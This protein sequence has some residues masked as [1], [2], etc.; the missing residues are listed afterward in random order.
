MGRLSTVEGFIFFDPLWRLENSKACLNSQLLL[1]GVLL[2]NASQFC[3]W[4]LCDWNRNL[5]DEKSF[6]CMPWIPF[7]NIISISI[8]MAVLEPWT[9]AMR[10]G[11]FA[12]CHLGSNDEK[13]ALCHG[14]VLAAHGELE[15]VCSWVYN[16]F[17]TKSFC[18][19]CLE[20]FGS[21]KS[22]ILHDKRCKFL[23]I[24]Y[25]LR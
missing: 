16:L 9:Y 15:R 4:E 23:T 24:H 17:A 19:M 5:A 6:R 7:F 25:N 14:S 11:A 13:Y 21:C 3:L 8:N 12:S 10:D 22:M 1:I 18:E 20:V 2:I